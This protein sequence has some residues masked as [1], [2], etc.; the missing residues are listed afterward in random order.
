M[1][2][3]TICVEYVALGPDP[4]ARAEAF[5]TLFADALPDLLVEKIRHYLQQK[6]TGE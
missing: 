3:G 4:G 2:S 1:V 6:D 5:R